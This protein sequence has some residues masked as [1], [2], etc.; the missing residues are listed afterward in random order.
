[1][2]FQSYSFGKSS[3]VS[4]L[5]IIIGFAFSLAACEWGDEIESLAQPDPDDFAVLSADTVTVNLSTIGT[6]SLQTGATLRLLLGTYKDPYF[7]RVKT[8]SFFQ[9]TIN[10]SE[11]VVQEAQYDSLI[12]SLRYDN[13]YSYGDSTKPMNLTVHKLLK[14]ITDI[15]ADAAY[16]NHN[17]TPYDPVAIGKATIIPRPRT[18]SVLRIRLSDVLGK[19]VFEKA[20]ANQLS[21]TDWIDLVK[22]LVLV[23]GSTDNSAIIGFRRDSVSTSVQLHYHT[24]S[25]SEY[26]KDSAVFQ[27][28][29]SYN[30]VTADPTG[31][32]L[33][34][35]PANKRIAL[36]STES[37]NMAFMQAGTG[38]MLRVD[39]PYLR[40]F[41]F[42]QYT[43]VNKAFLKIKPLRGTATNA[44]TLPPVL[45]VYR[46]DKNNQF[47]TDANGAPLAVSIL[48]GQGGAYS[49]LVNDLIKNE[50]YYRFDI[51]SYATE[52]MVSETGDVGGLI[53]RSS[54]FKATG[55]FRETGSEYSQSVD[56]LVVGD[57]RNTTEKGVELE[58]YYTKV[59]PK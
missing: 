29:A 44:Y 19:Q 58:L 15:P 42:V 1:M 4:K 54:P 12:L 30:H 53:I 40:N 50:Q 55:L 37:G 24:P 45:Y 13:A 57:Q 36:P 9:P 22:G 23:P 27:V 2:K 35:L 46:V 52:L 38:I 7:G 33:A 47:Y 41:K 14:D 6:D 32:Q 28:T 8:M 10:G 31:T 16:W 39:L 20:R 43:A 56:R 49:P 51:S 48:G 5:L 18:T 21:S 25:V 17:L 26:K 11:S 3:I 34:K 59:K